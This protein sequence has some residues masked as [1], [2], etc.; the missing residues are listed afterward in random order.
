M[1][2]PGILPLW[3][4]SRQLL[5]PERVQQ[6]W[7]SSI[8]VIKPQIIIY[9]GGNGLKRKWHVTIQ[10]NHHQ[11]HKYKP[12]FCCG[13]EAKIVFF[14]LFIPTSSCIDDPTNLWSNGQWIRFSFSNETSD[15]QSPFV[16]QWV[17][18]RTRVYMVKQHGSSL[19]LVCVNGWMRRKL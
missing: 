4:D 2:H 19:P 15:L 6:W 8:N 11:R 16:R 18:L 9:F 14:C 12:T 13:K 10:Y 7:M 3:P 17:K 5:W 1:L